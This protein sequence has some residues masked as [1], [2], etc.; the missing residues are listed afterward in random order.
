[1]NRGFSLIEV[2][3]SFGIVLSALLLIVG[4]FI[5]LFAW[6]SKTTDL[7]A[8][9]LAAEQVTAQTLYANLQNSTTRKTMFDAIAAGSYAPPGSLAQGTFTNPGGLK[10][11][12][13]IYASELTGIGS[14]P[15]N[16]TAK[17]DTVITWWGGGHQGAGQLKVELTRL[18]N[19][20]SRY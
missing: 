13:A 1:M 20:N 14:S 10:F 5:H 4:S 12:Y 15:D 9:A 6:G 7:A 11:D 2:L 16:R 18:V 17:I 19:E 8:G 3:I